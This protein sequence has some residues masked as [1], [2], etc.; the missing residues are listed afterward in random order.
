MRFVVLLFLTACAT[1]QLT[2]YQQGAYRPA[3]PARPGVGAPVVGQPGQVLT[4]S[5]A[6]RSPHR[7]PLPPAPEPGIWAGDSPRAAKQN[8]RQPEVLGVRLPIPH[9]ADEEADELPIVVCGVQLNKALDRFAHRS[10]AEALA[11][12]GDKECFVAE[13]NLLCLSGLRAKFIR[14]GLLDSLKAF[15]V[16]LQGARAFKDE[17]CHKGTRSH[18]VKALLTKFTTRWETEGPPR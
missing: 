5:D 12:K 2:E 3:P 11:T 13:I 9:E 17:K 14:D 7:R 15:E 1:P 8:P 4:P 16:T 6:P 18:G 10:E